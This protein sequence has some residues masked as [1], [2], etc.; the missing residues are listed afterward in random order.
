MKSTVR[1]GIALMIFLIGS[2]SASIAG[3][4]N[5]DQSEPLAKRSDIYCT[6]FIADAPPRVDLQVVG[7]EA[8]NL[9]VTFA[10]G[11]VVYLNRG[12]STGIQPGAV[13]NIIRPVGELNHPFSKKRLG[14]YVRELG[15]LRVV[16][17]GERTS[18][19]EITV[20]CDT[21]EFG[22]LLKPYE[23]SLGPAAR[24]ARPLP[25]Y[26]E[27]SGGINGQIVMSPGFHENLSANRVVFIDLGT[28]QDVHPG[29]S[30]TIYREIGAREG[31]TNTPKDNVVKR[32]SDGYDSDRFRGGEYSIQ[33]TR[34][35]RDRV[36]R[37]R[38]QLPRKV[39][40]ELVVL[41][42]EKSASVALITRTTAEVQIGDLVQRSN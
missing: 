30:F 38:P 11:D 20:S 4:Q 7:A 41:K 16:E 29:D 26:R 33:A 28:R 17:V 15:M 9:K 5:S 10:Q 40:G 34:A 42:V 27:G 39:L 35:P 24:D 14:Y 21:I 1:A 3:Q 25:K 19:A 6:G 8:E 37:E 13:Y 2:L 22:D 36:L 18:A 32:R 31:V 23:E 12:R